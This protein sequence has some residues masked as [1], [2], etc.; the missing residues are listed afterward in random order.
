MMPPKN[1][2]AMRG[3]VSLGTFL[4]AVLYAVA[5]HAACG[6]FGCLSGSQCSAVMSVG[7]DQVV[8]SS[9][10]RLGPRW[11]RTATN[12]TS[13][14]RRGTPIDLTWGFLA[15]GTTITGSEGTSGSDLI[16]TF[17]GLYGS[18]S[19]GV[20]TTPWFG[21]F[22]SSFDRWSELSGV[23]YTYESNDGG[24]PLN[25][26]STPRGQLG[27]YADARIGG[28]SIDGAT[29]ENTLAYN[30]FPTHGDMV[31]DTDNAGFFNRRSNNSR[32]L[33]NTLMHEIG[34]GLG[35]SHLESSNS[36]QLME[37]FISTAFD[38][39]QIDDILGIQRLYGD[40]LEKNG[41]NDGPGTSVDL[42]IFDDGEVWAIGTD[43]SS[44][45]VA[46]TQ[47]D[48]VSIDGIT[49]ADYFQFRV[50]ERSLV[51]IRLEQVGATYN[52][53]PQDGDQEPLVNSERNPLNLTLREDSGGG[54]TT[55]ADGV[56]EGVLAEAIVQ[57]ELLPGVDYFV[58]VSGSR[59]DVQL[60]ELALEV[61]AQPIPEPTTLVL[62][63]ATLLA[64]LAPSRRLGG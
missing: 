16:A 63:L 42:G 14:N 43:G 38:G 27:V 1:R 26:T 46:S 49:D 53:G 3:V 12:G 52:E 64:G 50:A 39:P 11:S 29:G 57:H 23:T 55:L 4:V 31:I 58:R 8:G 24:A 62:G 60:Y 15:D 56:D 28:H 37:P 22:E 5:V 47:T 7:D 19:G 18:G 59:D 20:E 45:Q 32:S 10:F 6:C 2:S 17:N 51:D 21:L 41:G 33:R 54:V 40:V 48:F 13:I 9:E 61:T 34:H 30:Y 35:L 44:T 25:N 36:R